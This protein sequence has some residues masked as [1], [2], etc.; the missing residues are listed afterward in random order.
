MYQKGNLERETKF[1]PD[2]TFRKQ[3][4][5]SL[6][7]SDKEK[8]NAAYNFIN[9]QGSNAPDSA[10]NFIERVEKGFISKM[11]TKKGQEIAKLQQYNDPTAHFRMIR[12]EIKKASQDG[13][14]KLQFPTGETAMKIEGLGDNG[15]GWGYNSLI[16]KP[17][18]LK[19]GIEVR[20]YSE[21]WIIT[22][23]L[24]DGK[25]KAMQKDKLFKDFKTQF[26]KISEEEITNFMQN[27]L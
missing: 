17:T 2:Y 1:T 26:P 11:E 7:K 20:R 10:K 3:V 19:I 4:E 24:G 15:Q 23:V 16:L 25:F 27:C 12:E 6:S 21:D 14:T 13:K 5:E 18:D 8:Y 22:D 9:S